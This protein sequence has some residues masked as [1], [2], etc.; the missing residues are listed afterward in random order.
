MNHQK[1][2][3]IEMVVLDQLARSEIKKVDD[4]VLRSSSITNL[5]IHIIIRTVEKETFLTN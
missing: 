1:E 5:K 2:K 3:P 4:S